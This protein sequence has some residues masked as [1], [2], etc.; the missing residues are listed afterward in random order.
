MGCVE[1]VRNEILKLKE[2]KSAQVQL[3]SPQATIIMHQ[4]IATGIL[5]QAIN[6]AGDYSIHETGNQENRMAGAGMITNSGS[7]TT[8][9]PIF[10]IFGYITGVTLLIQP[11]NN[12]FSI[13]L[14]MRHYMAGFF[15]V[16]SFFKLMNVKGF[17]EGYTSYD[18]IAKA[19]P[20]WG[21]IYPFIELILGVLYLTGSAIPGTAIATLIVMGISSIGVIQSLLK[22]QKIQCACLG[23]IIKLPLTKVTLIED[24]LMVAMSALTIIGV[25]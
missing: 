10:L 23:T 21:F 16:F 6:N 11:G 18:I 22:G 17:A 25:R 1:K 19:W 15:L 13:M 2:V 8:Y 12:P 4:H 5:Q 24:M 7:K 3:Q 9:F 20:V 14:W